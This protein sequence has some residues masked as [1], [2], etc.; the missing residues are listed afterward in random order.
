MYQTL[1]T[2]IKQK[3]AIISLNR[4]EHYNTFTIAMAE[5]LNQCLE[6]MEENDEVRVVLIRAMGKNFCT[7]IDVNYV[8]GKSQEEYLQW[9]RLMEKMNTTIASM[10]KPVIASV[11]GLALA[12]GIGLVA[13]CDL[14]LAAD[15]AR[16]G[17]TAINI[18]LFC[19][20]PAVPLYKS[21]GRKKTL[22]L[23]LTGEIISAKKALEFGLINKI[24]LTEKLEEKSFEYALK[25]AEK[26]PTA[27]QLGKKSFYQMED[28]PFAQALEM[29]NHHFAE[30]CATEEGQEGVQAF[31][32]KRQPS[33]KEER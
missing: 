30:L 8:D 1:L 24:F 33:W 32:E 27:M 28:Q 2:Q 5:E 15:N 26:S 9:V 19:M 18:G 20:G 11:K 29:T 4:P 25:L 10:G 23:I 21:L 31:L 13:A 16:F 12:N 22:E 7:G 3:V 17:A 14:A 6:A